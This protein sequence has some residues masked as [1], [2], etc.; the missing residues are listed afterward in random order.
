MKR[1]VQPDGPCCGCMCLPG[2][3]SLCIVISSDSDMAGCIR[4]AQDAGIRVVREHTMWFARR[5]FVSCSGSVPRALVPGAHRELQ[6]AKDLTDMHSFSLLL[7][8][9]RFCRSRFVQSIATKSRRPTSSRPTPL[10]GLGRRSS[11]W[12]RLRAGGE[13]RGH[14]IQRTQKEPAP[15][16]IVRGGLLMNPGFHSL[17]R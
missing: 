11:T 8:C 4:T 2:P 6:V 13:A 10:A 12:L 14:R 17:Q 15:H 5:V 1:N 7:S 9:F 3:K 16:I